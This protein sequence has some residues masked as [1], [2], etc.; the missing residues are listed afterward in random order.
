MVKMKS[1]KLIPYMAL[2]A[3]ALMVVGCAGD[4]SAQFTSTVPAAAAGPTPDRLNA[5]AG[6]PVVTTL[7]PTF[8]QAKAEAK[9][10][11]V[12]RRSN[13]WALLGAEAIFDREQTRERIVADT[14]GSFGAVYEL[15]DDKPVEET[16]VIE[17]Q[18]YRRLSGI[19]LGNGVAALIEMEDGRVYEIWPGVQIPG[20]EWVVI[21]I[22]AERA[23]LRRA[24]SRL[25]KEVIVPLGPRLSTGFGVGGGNNNGG[26][27]RG[28]D[29]AG[30]EGEGG[31]RSEDGSSG[32][33]GL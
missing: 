22:D 30:R 27:A 17:P 32:T 5:D 31:A 18:P 23:V 12:G 10:K 8:E 33:M 11:F 16:I 25:P 29:S 7:D 15:P 14:G 2:A 20:T 28:G 1:F 26:G 19:M 6:V 21:S 24:G 9:A 13:P 3:A 4:D